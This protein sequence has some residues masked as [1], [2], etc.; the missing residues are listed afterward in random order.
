VTALKLKLLSFSSEQSKV[1]HG[2]LPHVVR[3]CNKISFSIFFALLPSREKR[4][5]RGALL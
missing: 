4:T 3:Y 5:K 1:N 2:A